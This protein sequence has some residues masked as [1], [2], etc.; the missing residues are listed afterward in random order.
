MI[1]FGLTVDAPQVE[2]NW[3]LEDAYGCVGAQLPI[4]FRITEYG[5]DQSAVSAWVNTHIQ[6]GRGPSHI[7]YS[8]SD[9]IWERD[10]GKCQICNR[11]GG[12]VDHIFPKSKGGRG[13]PDNLWLLCSR[14]NLRKSFLYL[15]VNDIVICEGSE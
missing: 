14:C 1:S 9:Y 11:D 8:V 3:I 7:R 15:V 4:V 5:W 13:T 12:H 10:G 6:F 2:T